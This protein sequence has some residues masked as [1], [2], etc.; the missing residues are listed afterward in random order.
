MAGIDRS[1]PVPVY[2]QL[3]LLLKK[4]IEQGQLRSG[5]KIPTEAELCER[6][7]I[8]RTPVRQ[9]L[10]EL[11]QEGLLTRRAGRGTFVTVVTRPQITLRVTVSDER[12]RW[13]LEEVARLWN[14]VHDDK[15]ID[16]IFT[17][18]PLERLHDW[19]TLAVAQ[20]QAPDISVLDTVWVAEF[21]D[22][23]FLYGLE[24]LDPAW[25]SEV[26]EDL[27]PPLLLANSYQESQY[28]VPTNADAT[29]LWYRRDWMAAEGLTPPSTWSEL[30]SVGRHFL[31][32]A[33]RERYQLGAYPL[34]FAGGRGAG[35][36]TTYQLLP[37]LWS[38]GGDLIANG[39]IVLDSDA[40][41][42]TLEFLRDLVLKYK[43]ASPAVVGQPWD[44]SWRALAGGEVALAFGGT[45]ENYL[46]Q[47]FAG[48]DKATFQERLSFVPLPAGPGGAPA[49]LVGGMTY[50]IYR[51]SKQSEMALALLKLALTPQVLK[52]FSLETGQHPASISVT[53]SIGPDEDLFLSRSADLFIQ[54]R[55]RPS[56][57]VYDR[58]SAQF[59]E[60][61]E[62]CL[63]D[64]MAVEAAVRR[65]V[66]RIS[67]IT[68][69]P[70]A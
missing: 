37:V 49:Y 10:L 28:G 14:E 5:E 19:L 18:V 12:W 53:R 70:V 66:E 4:Q 51:Q 65:A 62:L 23:R 43:I 20:G 56:L 67:G 27:Y 11:T 30:V 61:V 21:A 6:Y 3:K 52:T 38:T 7:Q 9:A 22:R 54:G 24:E 68:D 26:R 55:S 8:S 16:L 48:W 44:K 45:Y 64:Q 29:V 41:Y 58:V 36:T 59:Q 25:A 46:I 35:E 31:Q 57:P 40:A 42:R 39:K 69:L 2:Y 15:N 47:T 1:I 17:T 13:P 34:T 32:P 63:T 50:G 33:V 60:M